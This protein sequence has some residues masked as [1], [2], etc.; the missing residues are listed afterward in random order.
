MAFLFAFKDGRKSLR[1]FWHLALN[2]IGID[3]GIR[4]FVRILLLSFLPAVTVAFAKGFGEKGFDWH[5]F[6]SIGLVVLLANF[7]NNFI[8][9]TDKIKDFLSP[10]SGRK[11]L[12]ER[13]AALAGIIKR[14]NLSLAKDSLSQAEVQQTVK[15]ILD[16]IVLHVRDYRGH[17]NIQKKEVFANLL[18]ERGDDLVV[19]CRDSVSESPQ[20]ERPIPAVY[21]KAGMLCGRAME[22]RK[23]LSIGMLTDE[24]PEGPQNKPYKSILALPLFTTSD[25]RV[26]GCVSVDCS[27][28]YFFQSFTPEAAENQMENSLQPYLQLITMAL[29]CFVGR[30]FDQT[31]ERLLTSS[32]Q[33]SLEKGR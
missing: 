23:P 25:D 21:S 9:G 27:R 29:E 12:N 13:K 4:G 2:L 14:I 6:F 5:L 1:K 31:A 28:P 30:S 16:L 32:N 8:S 7:L 33:V 18:I 20:Y 10:K 17:H 11:W 15:E 22:A 19:V 3:I 24:H 26:Y